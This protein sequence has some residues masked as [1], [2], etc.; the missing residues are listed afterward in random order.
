VD[1]FCGG[2]HFSSIFVCSCYPFLRV[3]ISKLIE[4]DSDGVGV[5]SVADRLKN[6]STNAFVFYQSLSSKQD[7]FQFHVCSFEFNCNSILA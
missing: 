1:W 4:F 6:N 2:L 7:T 5:K 3:R